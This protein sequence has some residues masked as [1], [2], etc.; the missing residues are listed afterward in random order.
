M[1]LISLCIPALAQFS[2]G[3]KAGV[4]VSNFA[5]SNNQSL[6]S[7]VYKNTT[8]FHVGVFGELPLAKKFSLLSELLYTQ[9]GTNV[10]NDITFG[11]LEIPVLA[12]YKVAK[13]ISIDIGPSASYQIASNVSS[14]YDAKFDLGI[15]GGVHVTIADKFLIIARYYRGFTAVDRISYNS[16]PNPGSAETMSFYNQNF[17][18]GFGYKIIR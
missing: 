2:A 6:I 12:S 5:N 7:D 8:G 13:I 15:N 14:I 17:Q 4:N 18:I 9:R 3:I 1:I 16:G 11:Y 10:G